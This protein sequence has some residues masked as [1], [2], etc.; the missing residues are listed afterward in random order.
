[1]SDFYDPNQNKDIRNTNRYDFEQRYRQMRFYDDVH[2]QKEEA[3]PLDARKKAQIAAKRRKAK[4]KRIIIRL[5]IVIVA[6]LLILTLVI[7]GVVGL[8]RGIVS[9]FGAGKDKETI[10]NLISSADVV[11]AG[12][13]YDQAISIIQ[14]YGK[15]YE[16]KKDLKAAISKYEEGKTALVKYEDNLS[17]PHLSF[18]TLIYDTKKAFDGDENSAKYDRNMITVSEFSSI[19]EALYDRDYVLVG[20]DDIAKMKDGT[21]ILRDIYL[22]KDKKPIVISQENVS[23]YRS[24]AGN[25]FASKLVIDDGGNP[26]CEYVHE[27]GKTSTGAY[28]LVPILENFIKKHPDFSYRGARAV[29][30]VTGYDGVLGYRTNP[31]GNDYHPD[32]EECA[33]KVVGRL[34]EL[35]YTFAGNTWDYT[36]Y[37]TNSVDHMKK[38]ADRWE[39]EVAPIVGNTDILILA[40]DSDISKNGEYASDNEKFNYLKS[41]GFSLFCPAV[42]GDSG[43]L[44]DTDYL[45]LGRY[46]INGRALYNPADM[47]SDFFDAEQILDVSRPK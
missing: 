15:K 5:S 9:L 26:V 35:G 1:M 34:K 17:I 2:A 13:D 16:K 23:Y 46:N 30:G 10:A 6:L 47:L 37:G 39:T 3:T 4:R 42:V 8:V 38:D 18:R 19:L 28:D 12:Y 11:A 41:K 36:S 7:S 45:R 24:L 22:P 43:G 40:G 29:L 44:A 14:S 31:N 33:K 27:G 21:V 20:L 25:G 32:E